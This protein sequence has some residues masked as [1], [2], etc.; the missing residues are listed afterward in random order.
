[1]EIKIKTARKENYS[2]GRSR[3]IKYIVIH[4][5]GNY[6]DTAE[7]QRGIFRAGS[8]QALAQRSLLRR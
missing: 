8:G 1:M 5:T 2:S 4:Y 3:K 6:G 7:K